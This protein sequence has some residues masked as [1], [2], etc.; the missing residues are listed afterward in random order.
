M[1]IYVC[2][3]IYISL[4]LNNREHSIFLVTQGTFIKMDQMLGHKGSAKEFL[5]VKIL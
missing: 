1:N 3:S 5:K 4:Q 2:I